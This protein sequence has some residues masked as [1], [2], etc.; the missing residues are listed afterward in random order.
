MHVFLVFQII[1][2]IFTCHWAV[3]SR[4]KS[5]YA[6]YECGAFVVSGENCETNIGF[7]CPFYLWILYPSKVF[8]KVLICKVS[9]HS[10][11]LSCFPVSNGNGLQWCQRLC[12]DATLFDQGGFFGQTKKLWFWARGTDNIFCNKE[13][14]SSEH[15]YVNIMNCIIDLKLFVPVCFPLDIQCPIFIIAHVQREH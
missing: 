3:Y 2:F 9:T 10:A 8:C 14:L 11:A 5:T 1:L 15:V 4:L 12:Q 7:P 6:I 13:K